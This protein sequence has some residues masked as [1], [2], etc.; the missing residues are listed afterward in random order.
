MERVALVH[1]KDGDFRRR[2]IGDRRKLPFRAVNQPGKPGHQPDMQRH[3]LVPC[4]LVESSGLCGMMQQLGRDRIGFDDFRRN[5]LL[6]PATTSAAL[7]VGLPLH[8]G[9]HAGYNAMVAE[10]VG[11]IEAVWSREVL[12][13]PHEATC[14][15]IMRL[16]LLQAGLRRR[17]LSS[18]PKKLRL[19]SKDPFRSGQDFTELDAM[20]DQLW[21]GTAMGT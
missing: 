20:A 7:R 13:K 17:L 3:H 21:A 1:A 5:G 8:R 2:R 6:L 16:D 19:N 14:A 10:R 12:R 15:A 18:G 4:Q 9:P 11:Q